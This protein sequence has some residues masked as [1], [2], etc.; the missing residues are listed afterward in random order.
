MCIIIGINS[1]HLIV[2]SDRFRHFQVDAL[3]KLIQFLNFYDVFHRPMMVYYLAYHLKKLNLILTLTFD[4]H[5]RIFFI[6]L[7]LIRFLKPL[8]QL[9]VLPLDQDISYSST[10]TPRILFSIEEECRTV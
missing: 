2:N 6:F 7:V 8:V 4:L 5:F 3:F 1:L 10:Y 9:W